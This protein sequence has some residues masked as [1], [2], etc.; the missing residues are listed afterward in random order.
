MNKNII[1][2]LFNLV[3]FLNFAS[4]DTTEPP[5][6]GNALALKLEDVSC[7]EAWLT[8]TTNLTLPTT[9]TLKQNNN[10]ISTINLSSADTLLYINSLLPNTNYYFQVFGTQNLLSSNVVNLTTL[11]TTSHNFSWQSWTFGEHSSSVLRDV[12]IIDGN[13]IWAVGEIYMNDSLGQPDPHPYGLAHWDGT[14]WNL[15]KVPYHDFNQSVKHP[16][17][18][19]AIDIIEGEIY[20]VS[21]ANLLNWNG[22]DWEEKAFFIEQIP[23]DGQVLK[24]WGSNGNN[25]YCVGRNGAIYYYF[26]TSWQKIESGTE[27]NIGDIWGIPD[28]NGSYNKYL[29]ADN[30]MLIIDNNNQLSRIDA[31]PGHSLSSA[32]GISNRLIYTAGGYGLSLYKNYFWEKINELNVNTIYNVRGQ[33]YNDVFGLSSTFLILHFNGFNWQY[34]NVGT[35]NVYYRQ[36][37]KNNLIAAVGRQDQ[38]AIITLIRRNY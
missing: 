6:D 10:T 25:I 32:W 34:I 17:P 11:D 26:G 1:F 8:L 14:K 30:S 38:K 29:A 27:L 36:D 35:S 7:T 5:V 9:V 21:Y 33:N 3:L 31:E 4:C 24:M 12:T 19:F 37:V 23:F 2:F 20:V 16:G 18:L 28:G 13:N 22:N 15:M